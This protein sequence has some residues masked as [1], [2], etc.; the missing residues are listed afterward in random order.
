M[1]KAFRR[2]VGE[3]SLSSL[4]ADS[5]APSAP[6]FV[7]P[8]NDLPIAPSR[9]KHAWLVTSARPI[10]PDGFVAWP[11]RNSFA[12]VDLKLDTRQPQIKRRIL[13]SPSKFDGDFMRT[14]VPI[15]KAESAH[16]ARV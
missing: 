16:A 4:V 1:S 3:E 8:F 11:Q 12:V 15:S 2:I 9:H 5:G 14:F 7:W 6:P 10:L 13:L